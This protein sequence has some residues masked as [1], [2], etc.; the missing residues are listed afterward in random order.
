MHRRLATTCL[1]RLFACLL[2][3]TL[4]YKGR[5]DRRRKTTSPGEL[6]GTPSRCFQNTYASGPLRRLPFPDRPPLGELLLESLALTENE[7]RRLMKR[8][9]IKVDKLRRWIEAHH[10]IKSPWVLYA[11][12]CSQNPPNPATGTC[13]VHPRAGITTR[14]WITIPKPAPVMGN[15]GRTTRLRAAGCDQTRTAAATTSQ[16]RRALIDTRTP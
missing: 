13:S 3:A 8:R 1:S 15:S 12:D 7:G 10:R 5:T 14:N 16:T 9:S 2:S 6:M 4:A 11:T